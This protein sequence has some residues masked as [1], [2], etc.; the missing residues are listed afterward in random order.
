MSLRKIFLTTFALTLIICVQSALAIPLIPL[1]KFFDNPL[2]DNCQISPDGNW[3]SCLKPYQGKLNVFVRDSLS[4]SES[5]VT[6][7]TER[8]VLNYFWSANSK[9]ILYL[10]DHLGDENY[11]LFSVSIK[12]KTS[13]NLTPF[14]NTTVEIV[15]IPFNSEEI[16]ISMNKRNPELMDAYWLNI[17][18][19]K[20]RVAAENPGN[21]TAYLADLTNQVR[22]ATAISANGETE[23]HARTTEQEPWRL[24]KRYP[25]EDITS[26]LAFHQDG[27]RIYVKS[28]FGR[29]LSALCLL[30]LST[31]EETVVHQ[32][33]ENES[34]LVNAI[35]DS[36]THQLLAVQYE[37]DK[38]RFYGMTPE[39][40]RD[41]E[42][43]RK[44][45]PDNFYLSSRSDDHSRWV[46]AYYSPTNP[47]Q[48]FLYQRDKAK[49]KLLEESRPWLKAEMLSPCEPIAFQTKDG[50]TIRGYLTLPRDSEK[51]N[52]PMVLFVHGGPWERDRWQFDSVA[53]FLAN[54]GYAVL[55]INFRGSTGFGKK[56]ATAAKKEFAQKMHQDLIDGVNWVVD[57]K[58]ADPKRV[59]IIGLSYGGY[60]T[61]VGLTFTPDTFA[62]GVDFAGASSLITLIESFP[63]SWK[64]FLARRWY[65]FVGD[66]SKAEDREDMKKRSPLFYAD[67]I[68][69]PLMIYQGVNDPRVTKEQADQMVIALHDRGINTQYLVA[70]DEGHGLDNP[71]NMLAVFHAT[72]NFLADCIQGKVQEKVGPEIEQQLQL[73]MVD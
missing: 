70:K 18:N 3:I 29:N 32:D 60:A 20:L 61:L 12:S 21:F 26:V 6:S 30:D 40:E 69:A 36:K 33:P 39:I 48:T 45:S 4:N 53:Q 55:Q 22:V 25:I 16:L 31:G 23:I 57:K 15:S 73:M 72:E 66:P 8:P 50:F 7:E 47:G 38:V 13:V 62:C 43:I 41:L 42:S 17:N 24:V 54:R 27:K 11:N 10:Q 59:A 67:R 65:P 63:P 5:I 34:D 14:P 9:S 71:I 46:V 1:E 2:V 56:F 19:G 52:L 49:L 37:G 58:I 28:S 35:F 44:A 64:P 51:K 68:K